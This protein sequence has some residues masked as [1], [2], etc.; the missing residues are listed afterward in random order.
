MQWWMVEDV[1]FGGVY[2]VAFS[3]LVVFLGAWVYWLIKPWLLKRQQERLWQREFVAD[4]LAEGR[5]NLVAT[6]QPQ[7]VEWD[8]AE[9]GPKWKGE[10]FRDYQARWAEWYTTERKV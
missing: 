9:R 10:S 8:E 4:M 2:V 6:Q 5:A 3:M 1:L 7:E